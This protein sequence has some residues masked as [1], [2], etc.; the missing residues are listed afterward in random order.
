MIKLFHLLRF[1]CGCGGGRADV[2]QEWGGKKCLEPLL[3]SLAL[4]LAI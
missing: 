1:D 2:L 4:V 3:V